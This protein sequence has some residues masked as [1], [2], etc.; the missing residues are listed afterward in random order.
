[1]AQ[2]ALSSADQLRHI[3]E[4][5]HAIADDYDIPS[6]S[7]TRVEMLIGRVEQAAAD[8]RAVVRGPGRS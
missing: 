1:M 4:D 2:P 6:K 8:C 3:A 7:M 5:L